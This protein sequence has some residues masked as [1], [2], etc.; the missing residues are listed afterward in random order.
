VP[1][2]SS[3]FVTRPVDDKREFIDRLEALRGVAAMMVAL[4]HSVAVFLSS[5]PQWWLTKTLFNGRAAVTIFFVLSGF[6]LGLSLRRSRDS[7]VPGYIQFVLRRG[8]RIYPALAVTSAVIFGYFWWAYHSPVHPATTS[9]FQSLYA[10]QPT[11]SD[12]WRNLTLRD[13]SINEVT[14]TLRVELFGSAV[15]PLMHAWAQASGR[16]GKLGLL[17]GLIG[18]AWLTR[19]RLGSSFF[20]FMFYLGYLLPE[21]GPPMMA[22]LRRKKF[23]QGAVVVGT[24]LCLLSRWGYEQPFESFMV[25]ALGATVLIAG[26]LYGPEFWPYRLLDTPVARFY[27][28]ISYSF[29]LVHLCVMYVT[30]TGL[31]F[32]LPPDLL[33]KGWMCWGMLLALVSVALATPL[34]W[35]CYQW[36]ERP[37][38]AVGKRVCACFRRSPTEK[39]PVSA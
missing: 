11:W 26:I 4:G 6:V 13:F 2:T 32:R 17:A 14:W 24:V 28:R 34:S 1:I 18:L 9:W 29:Y 27:G 3:D 8:F 39:Q 16:R 5:E 36:L 7:F 31:F 37:A 12:L 35:A 22:W 20:L 21:I 38:I 10:T 19:G 25:E 33:G 23:A 30:V 15:L